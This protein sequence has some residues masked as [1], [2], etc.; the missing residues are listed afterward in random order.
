MLVVCLVVLIVLVLVLLLCFLF[1][2]IAEDGLLTI[3]RHNSCRFA[4]HIAFQQSINSTSSYR[5]HPV[6]GVEAM[7][8]SSYKRQSLVNQ[9]KNIGA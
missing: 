9:L 7:H 8:S 4:G 2:L 1:V 5:R 6:V 3:I